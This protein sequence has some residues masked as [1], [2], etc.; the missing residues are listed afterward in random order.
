MMMDGLGT[1]VLVLLDSKASSPATPGVHFSI[2]NEGRPEDRCALHDLHQINQRENER[3]FLCGNFEAC[4]HVA[5]AELII[6]WG[7]TRSLVSN[8]LSLS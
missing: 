2:E 6:S 8:N 3:F 5:W 7:Q 4:R 1:W